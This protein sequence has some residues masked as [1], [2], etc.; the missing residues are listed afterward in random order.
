MQN[1]DSR[2]FLI[3]CFKAWHLIAQ[4]VEG[5]PKVVSAFSLRVIVFAP[6][7]WLGRCA[8]RDG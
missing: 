2:W 8:V 5:V 1:L 4:E 6:P 7:D 3:D